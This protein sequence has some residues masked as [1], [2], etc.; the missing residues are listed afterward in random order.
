MAR[1]IS[2]VSGAKTRPHTSGDVNGLPREAI[3][4]L[5]SAVYTTDAEGRI[6]FY[7]GAAAV[8]WGCRPELGDSK[9]CGSWNGKPL[10]HDE[11]P[12]DHGAQAK[13]E[14]PMRLRDNKLGYP[15]G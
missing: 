13:N 3:E 1:I 10:S 11:C 15:H 5:P 6:T 12:M 2:S 7:N 8:L 14:G 4:A 9:F